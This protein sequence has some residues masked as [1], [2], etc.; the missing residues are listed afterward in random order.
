MK[1]IFFYNV[2]EKYGFMS[3]FAYYGFWHFGKFWKTSE[4]FYQMQKFDCPQIINDI[5]EARTPIS[6]AIIAHS[7]INYIKSDWNDIREMAMYNA[8]KYKFT[9]NI[10]TKNKL[11][12]T[13]YSLLIEN[14]LDDY[15]WGCG[16][17][18]TGE[19]RLG[20][21]LMFYRDFDI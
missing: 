12:E 7:N 10:S 14:S 6:A 4:H 9:Q 16:L 21:L 17:L 18:G 20:K 11:L 15:Y 19:N 5:Y 1:K 8:I 13:R 3:N 2:T